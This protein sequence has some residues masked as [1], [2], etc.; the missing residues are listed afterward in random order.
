[1]DPYRFH[2]RF[3]PREEG[4]TNRRQ[5][6]LEVQV[7]QGVSL[8]ENRQCSAAAETVDRLGSYLW[9]IGRSRMTG[10]SPF[11]ARP[12]SASPSAPSI[13]LAVCRPEPR[14][15]VSSD[16]DSGLQS[17]EGIVVLQP[18][19]AAAPPSGTAITIP[20]LYSQGTST[21]CQICPPQRDDQTASLCGTTT[22]GLEAHSRN[23][24]WKLGS[25]HRA[26]NVERVALLCANSWSGGLPWEQRCG[27]RCEDDCASSGAV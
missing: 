5:I 20:G 21:H 9:R 7:L 25:S 22:D 14:L 11:C 23:R 17:D 8:A 1:M 4:G 10:S 15:A 19:S 13:K 6:W 26:S 18:Q 12:G 16:H 24:R 3:F 27:R 2:N